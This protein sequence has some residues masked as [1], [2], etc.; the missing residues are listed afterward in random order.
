MAPLMVS[1]KSHFQK[2]TASE[3][4]VIYLTGNKESPDDKHYIEPVDK[5]PEYILNDTILDCYSSWCNAGDTVSD[6]ITEYRK[7]SGYDVFLGKVDIPCV[8]EFALPQRRYFRRYFH[9]APAF[10]R[11]ES[12]LTKGH[13]K[14]IAF[15]TSYDFLWE[16]NTWNAFTTA[17]NY[18]IS[19]M[20]PN[21][22]VS[23]KKQFSYTL[24]ELMSLPPDPDKFFPGG[25]IYRES[26]DRFH[27]YQTKETS[28]FAFS[29]DKL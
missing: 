18:L 27:S 24:T 14:H 1:D 21:Y 26:A 6:I 4:N 29:G 3:K 19:L 22:E 12:E 25:S 2:I 11:L 5:L 10:P 17:H 15:F 7:T 13:T 28:G 16:T 23:S 9:F 20:L 8:Y